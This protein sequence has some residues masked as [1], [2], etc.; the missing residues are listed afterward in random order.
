MHGH[1][2]L[3]S[4]EWKV[5]KEGNALFND[6]LNTFYLQLYVI[7]PFRQREMKPAATIWATLFD[8]QQGVIYMHQPTDRITHTMAFVTS[9]VEHWLERETAASNEWKVSARAQM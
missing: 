3:A 1:C 4:N 2:V 8:S 5:R 9:V 7:E 6:T